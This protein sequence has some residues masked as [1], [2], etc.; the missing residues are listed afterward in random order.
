MRIKTCVFLFAVT[1]GLIACASNQP[2]AVTHDG[3]VR[4]TQVK[5]ADVYRKPGV[6]LA[7]FDEYG[8]QPCTVAFRKNWLR[9]QNRSTASLSSRVTRQD[10][11]RIK[12]SLSA[13]CD[14]Y[15]REALQEPPAY[16]LVESFADG[17]AVLVLRPSI[18]D[19]DVTAPDKLTAGRSRTYTTS[20]GE[21]T[22]FLEGRDGTTGEVLFRVVDR[23]REPDMT[24]LEWTNS[25]TNKADADR[26]LRYWS[27]RLRK[28]LD[29]ARGK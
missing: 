28:A 27:S 13:Q 17:E 19:L 2:P 6:S 10:V 18:I 8:L 23:R 21:M 5:H 11:D 12:D 15:F 3:L 9:D 7:D 24:R 22:L 1:A 4:D 26:A 14:R 29:N 16:R 25:I 20:S